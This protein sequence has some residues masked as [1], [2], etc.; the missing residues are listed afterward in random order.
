MLKLSKVLA[1]KSFEE[2]K[3]AWGRDASGE[4]FIRCGC[5][6]CINLDPQHKIDNNGVINPSV[7]HDDPKCGWHQFVQL[8]DYN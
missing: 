2:P 8:L 6:K 5:G 3:P 7:W 4:I 1:R